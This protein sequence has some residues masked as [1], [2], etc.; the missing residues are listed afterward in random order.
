MKL[1]TAILALA[2]LIVVPLSISLLCRSGSTNVLERLRLGNVFID[3]R[4]AQIIKSTGVIQ[5]AVYLISSKASN[6]DDEFQAWI[7]SEKGE[8][9]P[10][11]LKSNFTM[12][13]SKI[14]SEHLV[15][16]HPICAD[17]VEGNYLEPVPASPFS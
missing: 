9:T 4:K 10:D 7:K 2:A 5:N 13:G 12:L 6:L 16:K 17:M 8:L 14:E 1:R 11:L 3:S 15:L